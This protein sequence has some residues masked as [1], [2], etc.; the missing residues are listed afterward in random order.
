[1]G[2]RSFEGL[3]TLFEGGRT[4]FGV[5]TAIR[6]LMPGEST[7]C[8][9]NRKTAIHRLCGE[10]NIPETDKLFEETAICR[11]LE[12]LSDKLSFLGK[13]TAICQLLGEQTVFYWER[14]PFVNPAVRKVSKLS[15]AERDCH[16]LSV[17]GTNCLLLGETAICSP[18][19]RK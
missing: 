18:Y 2:P 3:M 13:K 11:S 16:L 19:W 12:Y 17:R 6:R 14:L 1:M 9:P 8:F 7:N 10:L 15:S 5:K 4:V